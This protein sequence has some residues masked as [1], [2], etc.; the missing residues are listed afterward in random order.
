MGFRFFSDKRRP[1][2]MGPYPMERVPRG[3]MPDLTGLAL[4][5]PLEFR[6]PGEPSSVVNAMGE[7]QAMMDAI[8]D[9][10][11][12]KVRSGIPGD[13]IERSNHL[14]AFGY[15]SDASMVGICRLPGAARLA[16][17]YLNPD[18]DRLANDLPGVILGAGRLCVSDP[19]ARNPRYPGNPGRPEFYT[20]KLF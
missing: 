14:K 4:S 16:E 15:F 2:H 13:G 6:R 20:V 18:I 17:P 12:N 11:V 3:A 8:R 7:Y 10:F 1:V 5:P 9:G 19:R